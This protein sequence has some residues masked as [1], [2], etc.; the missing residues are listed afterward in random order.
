ME[1]RFFPYQDSYLEKHF[2][3]SDDHG[4]Y[5]LITCTAP[6]D[7]PGTRAHY[8]WNGLLPPPGRHWAWKREQMEAFEREG[9]LVHSSNGVPRLKRYSHEGSG[10]PVQDVWLDIN[11]L[12]S[13]SRERTGFETQKP[14]ALLE[15]IITASSHPGDLVLD[16]FA[17]SG[18]TAVAA[19][20]LKRSWV[21]M[22]SSLIA[23]AITLARVR[24]EVNLASVCLDGFPT[25][26]ADA[27]RLLRAEPAAFGIWGTSML[28]SIPDRDGT[29]PTVVVGAGTLV[30]RSRRVEILS[31]V[32]I[33]GRLEMA[34]PATER[35]RLSKLGVIL[36]H[37]RSADA[38]QQWL[39]RRVNIPAH[40]VDLE[41][42]VDAHANKSGLS[43]R[44]PTLLRKAS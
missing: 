40:V 15:R 6:G 35:G 38:A 29:N 9:R 25:D 41:H 7:R 36:R 14:V 18:T 13:H 33:T 1:S 22:D 31:W 44:L 8:E 27:R 26:T 11:R 4:C 32:P 12:D 28:A 3:Q 43:S 5:Q 23:C 20:R 21:A 16:P 42:L 17:G 39:S 19:E 2:R 34:V 24:Q 37:N 30:A 10:V